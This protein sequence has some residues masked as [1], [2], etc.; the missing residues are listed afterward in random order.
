MLFQCQKIL[1][2]RKCLNCL[3]FLQGVIGCVH[4]LLQ[5][6][7]AK[8]DLLHILAASFGTGKKTDII[9]MSMG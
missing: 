2:N 1:T 4:F 6:F 7:W 5:R 8:F 3:M 9:E